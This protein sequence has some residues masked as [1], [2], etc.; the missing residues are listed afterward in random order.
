[1]NLNVQTV[2]NFM[3]SWAPPGFASSWDTV[4]LHTGNPSSPVKAV[5]VCLSVTPEAVAQAKEQG[6]QLIIAHHPLIFRPLKSL[7]EDTPHGRLCADL[8]RHQIACFSAHTN[9]DIA[10]GGVNDVLAEKLGL[11]E[12]APLFKDDSQKQLK[13]F[14][15]LPAD[16]VDA[17]RDALADA[18]AGIIGGYSHCSFQSEGQGSFFAGQ[19]TNP[20]TGGRDQLN[21]EEEVKLEMI[22]P[23]AKKATVLKALLKHHPYEEPAY[24]LIA[25][26]NPDPHRGLGR[27]GSLE[28]AIP[29]AAFAEEVKKA[30]ALPYLTY[31]GAGD[32]MVQHVAVLGGSGGKLVASVP[33][34]TDVYVTGDLGYHD[35]ELAAS[36]GL[37]CVDAGHWGTELPI[38]EEVT[39]RLKEAFPEIEIIPWFEAAPGTSL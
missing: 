27:M 38:V 8:V 20:Y 30:L 12:I 13:F 7:R 3:E 35:A 2:I 28:T 21:V 14:T 4:G 6:A 18:G 17:L 39:K 23:E 26:E 1:M 9:L 37:A 29:L 25:L 31:Y 36:R 19:G 33:F 24:D 22:L 15:F 32:K 16:Q 5:L 10:E 11:Q 34:D